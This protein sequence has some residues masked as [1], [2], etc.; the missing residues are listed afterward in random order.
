MG[1]TIEGVLGKGRQAG[2]DKLQA[3]KQKVTD[4]VQGYD[5]GDFGGFGMAD[6]FLCLGSHP[7]VASH[8]Y[9]HDVCDF[10][11]PRPH[12]CESLQPENFLRHTLPPQ[13][14]TVVMLPR[15]SLPSISK[16]LLS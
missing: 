1:P 9:D 8:D 3:W 11:P 6:G 12:S 13:L 7:I 16:L 15:P 10:C 2:I 5:D 4:L 14:M